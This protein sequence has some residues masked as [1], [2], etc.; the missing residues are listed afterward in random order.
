[1]TIDS[2][3]W[4]TAAGTEDLAA[5]AASGDEAAFATLTERHRRELHVHC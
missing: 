2:T 1:M 3:G 5:A 4:A